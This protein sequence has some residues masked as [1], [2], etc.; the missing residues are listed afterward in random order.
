MPGEWDEVI[1]VRAR[2]SL[3]AAQ[4]L[5]ADADPA[6]HQWIRAV[7]AG[8]FALEVV[9]TGESALE[10]IAA[11]TAR[12]VILGAR[13]TDMMPADLVTRCSQWLTG[14]RKGPITFLLADDAGALPDVDERQIKVFYRLVRSMPAERVRE[15]ISQG[16]AVLPVAPP[17]ESD[18]ALAA[19]VAEHAKQIGAATEASDAARLAIAATTVLVGAD[20][21]RCLYCDDDS[22]TLWSGTDEPTAAE[23]V[24]PLDDGHASGGI[25]GFAVRTVASVA[26]PHAAHDPM[27]QPSIDDPAG[28]GRERIAVQPVLGPDGHVHAVLVAVRDER[29][30]P[31]SAG[32][33]DKLEAL[34]T[35]WSPYLMQLSM[36]IEADD[37]LGDRL[38]RGQSEIFRQEAIDNL[39]KRGARGDVV[40]VHP[41]WIRAAYWL[42]LAALAGVGSFAAVAH[43]DQ[44]AEG[45]AVVRFTG[46]SEV[47]AF[48]AGTVDSLEVKPGDRVAAGATLARLHDAQ[49]VAKLQALETDFE[50]KLVAYLQTPGNPAVA[51]DLAAVMSLRD[52]AKAVV[53]S[54]V[55]RAPHAGVVKEVLVRNGQHVEPGKVIVTIVENAATEGLSVFAF[56]PGSERP[57]LH[58]HQHLRFTLPGYRGARIEGE[59]FAVSSSVV[60]A[61]EARTY[62]GERLGESLP[63]SGPVVVVQAL[64][65][66]PEF[67]SD[68]QKFQLH[69]G[70]L[71]VAEIKL[72]SRSVLESLVPGLHR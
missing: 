44:Y 68:G 13:L 40:R 45:P 56:L 24:D 28:T 53:D 57:R 23:D 52:N 55:I 71:G 11:G 41:G 14:E 29:K 37:I 19:L 35:A 42:V 31:F 21:A 63:L 34:A 7:V 70:M 4:V 8:H 25:T 18:P 16:A 17:H 33:L 2:P 22:G 10:R 38:D 36:R 64:L 62:A 58:R 27:Y 30:P 51:K 46:R 47:V 67:E 6:A 9:E 69:D 61:A 3:G 20:R 54:R 12:I 15:L 60:G 65:V 48:E 26:L 39:M 43:V 59:V 1:R 32:D 49:E 72:Q 5:L 50:A 66:S